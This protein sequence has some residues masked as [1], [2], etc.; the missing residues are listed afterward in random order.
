MG[1]SLSAALV[2]V[3]A[4]VMFVPIL[5]GGMQASSPPPAAAVGGGLNA[6]AVPAQYRDAVARAGKVCDLVPAAAIAAQIEQESGWNPRA[7]SPVGARGIAQFMPATWKQWGKD[8]DG[9]GQ[10]NPEDPDDAIDAQARFMCALAKQTQAWV[11]NGVVTGDPLELAWAAY[12]AGPGAVQQYGGI[13][14]FSETQGYVAAIRAGMAKYLAADAPIGK[15][16][17]FGNP[18]AGEQYVLTSPFG[19]RASPC[20]GCSSNHQGQDFG[21]AEG[22][23]IHAAC[24]GRVVFVGWMDGYG[25]YTGIDCGGGILTGYAH[26][27]ATAVSVGDTVKTGQ[28]IGAVG[29]TGVGTGDHLHFEVRRGYRGGN[30]LSARAVDPAKFLRSH[31]VKL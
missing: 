31:G 13:P 23:T 10:N 16:G 24:T 11:R 30:P 27:S 19:P 22:T 17:K 29:H 14:P 28:N 7:V 8:A 25:N 12:N 18:L 26:Q 20:T 9:D 5:F 6:S 4:L 2:G 15:G 1:K 3:V 21:A